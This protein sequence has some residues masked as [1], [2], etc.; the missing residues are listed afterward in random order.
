MVVNPVSDKHVNI[1]VSEYFL[2]QLDQGLL[3]LE[4]PA[5]REVDI[6]QKARHINES[7]ASKVKC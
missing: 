4:L 5:I 3:K 1:V 2:R 6:R 7:E